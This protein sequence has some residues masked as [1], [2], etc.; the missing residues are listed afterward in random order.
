VYQQSISSQF[1]NSNRNISIFQFLNSSNCSLPLLSLFQFIQLPVNT[2]VFSS[3]PKPQSTFPGSSSSKIYSF[4]QL[5]FICFDYPTQAA[6]CPSSSFHL[7]PLNSLLGINPSSSFLFICL[8]LSVRLQSFQQ[9]FTFSPSSNCHLWS[10]QQLSP[11][12]HPAH[13]FTLQSTA[14][15]TL[16]SAALFT[17]QSLQPCSLSSLSAQF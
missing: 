14:L 2:P 3:F 9:L 7:T 12:V 17:L 1:L 16:Q 4:T 8:F 6:L 10:I 5:R 15:F 11:L 13:L